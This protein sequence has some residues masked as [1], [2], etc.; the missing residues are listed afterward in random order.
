MRGET[1]L[2][3]ES[4]LEVDRLGGGLLKPVRRRDAS[5]R[6]LIVDGRVHLGVEHPEAAAH[7][8]ERLEAQAGG[9]DRG[10]AR[11]RTAAR[12]E[13][14]Q[15]PHAVVVVTVD[16]AAV[17][18]INRVDRH[19]DGHVAPVEGTLERLGQL[20]RHPGGQ[21]RHA[22]ADAAPARAAA[23]IAAAVGEACVDSHGDRLVALEAQLAHLQPEA[24]QRHSEAIRSHQKLSEAIRSYQKPSSPTCSRRPTRGNQKQSVALGGAQ[25][26]SEVLG[27]ARA[28]SACG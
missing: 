26:P 8:A 23:P 27:G 24:D 17:R 16:E 28:R 1:R 11:E 13:A 9:D 6:A 2:A 21:P 12:V 19:L 20:R 5:H 14:V 3:V 15:P 4:E 10:V 7:V 25:W 18:V 22:A